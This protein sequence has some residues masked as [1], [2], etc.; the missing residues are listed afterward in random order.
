MPTECIQNVLAPHSSV[1]ERTVLGALLMDS[2]AIYQIADKLSP[3]DFFDPVH[4]EIYHVMQKLTKQGTGVDFVTVIAS[5]G[6]SLRFRNVGGSAFLAEITAEV[7]TASHIDHYVKIVVDHS[8]KRR[9][10]AFGEKLKSLG[11]DCELTAED[12]LE[13]AERGLLDLSSS[14]TGADPVPIGEL[15]YERFQR[16]SALYEAD[17]AEDLQ[18][19]PSGFPA[20]DRKLTG[21]A[22]G[23]LVILAARPGMG[24]TALALDFAKYAACEKGKSVVVFSLEMSA[25][26]VFDRMVAK[27]LNVPAWQLGQGKFD[28]A[29]MGRMG[30]AMDR[31]GA[32]PIAIDDSSSTVFE[33]SSRARRHKMR[34]GLDLVIVDYLQ[35]VSVDERWARENQTQRMSYI[36][37]SLKQL[38][39]EL[40]VPVIALSQLNREVEKRAGNRPMLSDLR[41]SGSIEQ[42]ADRILMLYREEY[43]DE[44][45]DRP[46]LT[47][48]YIRKNRQGPTGSVELFFESETMS[49]ETPAGR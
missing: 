1:A 4:S 48:V 18:G 37:R 28:E 5:L 44:D 23:Q 30:N 27:E 42:D 24:K 10:L 11:S 33:I 31:I 43:Y 29:T 15:R 8:Q 39:R 14:Y 45:C 2:D 25:E 38:A 21:F 47:D 49:F 16:Y 36:S 46:G 7:P 3:D 41:D 35:L 34:F 19:I 22:P 20:I 6:E 9:L 17:E 12:A 13:S 32:Y 40:D 26:E